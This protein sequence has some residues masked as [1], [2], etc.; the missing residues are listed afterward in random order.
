MVGPPPRRERLV[1]SVGERSRVGEIARAFGGSAFAGLA[2]SGGRGSPGRIAA[3]RHDTP[4]RGRDGRAPR[5]RALRRLGWTGGPGGGGRIAVRRA[6]PGEQPRVR[7]HPPCPWREPD[8]RP[9]EG[10]LRVRN[11]PGADDGDLPGQRRPERLGAAGREPGPGRLVH[12]VGDRVLR[13]VLAAQSCARRDDDL[14]AHVPL[15]PDLA[16]RRPGQL[17]P[18]ELQ[19]HAVAGD[20]AAEQL[21]AG[22]LRLHDPADP[23]RDG[24]GRPLQGHVIPTG[25][26]RARAVETTGPRSRRPWP[27]ARPWC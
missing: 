2:A 19:H 26:S 17:V 20:R 9:P 8:P 3:T 11:R 1:P 6:L 24:G 18:A 10:R 25:C 21:Y 7:P 22:E 15:Q 4:A 13:P 16:R 23:C 27:A 12:L 5:R 14:R